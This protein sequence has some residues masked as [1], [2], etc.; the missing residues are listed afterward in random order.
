MNIAREDVKKHPEAGVYIYG[1]F[2]EGASWDEKLGLIDQK[3]GEMRCDMPLIWFKTTKEMKNNQN[4]D[5]DD[6]EGGEDEIFTYTCP[7]FKTGKRASII[8]SSG[9][10][11]EKIIDVDLPSRFKKEYWTLRGT[12]LLSQIED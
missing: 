3:E 4:E 7:L 8:A 10:S 2:L 11:N 1:L 9:N 6:D 5:D 12:A